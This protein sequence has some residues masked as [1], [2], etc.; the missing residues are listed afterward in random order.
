MAHEPDWPL[1]D[2]ITPLTRHDLQDQLIPKQLVGSRQGN[3]GFDLRLPLG[4]RPFSPVAVTE[5]AVLDL[6]KP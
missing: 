3:V 6:N 4:P 1:R 5:L 2:V